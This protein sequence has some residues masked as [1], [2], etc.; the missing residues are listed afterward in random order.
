MLA[1]PLPISLVCSED[2][3]RYCTLDDPAP[4][5]KTQDLTPL[6]S[7][8]SKTAA[9]EFPSESSEVDRPNDLQPLRLGGEVVPDADSGLRDELSGS[10]EDE[11]LACEAAGYDNYD[12]SDRDYTAC[13]ASNCGYCGHCGY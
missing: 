6:V 5:L 12:D 4:P 10:E 3:S 13:S 7:E 1:L 11:I 8:T 9:T 2:L